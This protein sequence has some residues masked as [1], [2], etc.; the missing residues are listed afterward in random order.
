MRHAFR[1][2]LSNPAFTAAAA[3][4]LAAAIGANA[5]IFSVINGVLL[6]PLPFAEPER[7]VG[8]WHVAPGIAP[9]PMN[10][11]PSTYFTYREDGRVFQDIGLWDDTSVTV[12][13]RGEP[14]Q[15]EA[16]VVT[17]GTLPVLGVRPALGRTFTKEDDAPGPADTVMLS[18]EYWLRL[19]NGNA[20]AIGQSLMVNGRPREI[21]GVLPEDFRFL[22]YNP[23]IVLPFRFN[24]AEIFLGNFSYQGLARLKPGVTLEQ[25]NADVARLIPTMLDRFRMP[26]GF[27]REMFAGVR[28]GPLVR[29][30]EIDV[31]GDI[32]RMLWVLFGTVGLV[33]LVAC[34]N[35]ANLFLVRAEGR[36]QELA[37]RMALGA[38]TKRVARE[39][40]AEST[41]LS[42]F[43]GVIGLGLA[44]AGIRLL[45]YLQP[46]RLPRLS[47]IS[48]DPIVVLYTLGVSMVA[49]LLFGL[50]PVLK[51][52][53]PQLANA[54]KEN[55]RGSSDGRERHR[56]RNTLVVAQIALAAV[57]LV[58]SGLML[59]TFAAMRDVSPGFV[60]PENILTMRISIPQ[61][62]IESADQV[63][64]THQD[65]VRR[66]EAIAGVESV[67][68]SSSVTMDG[69]S[70][71]DPIFVED[72]PAPE[73]QVPQLRRF[74]WIGEKY[75]QTMG[76]PIVAGRAIT[77]NDILNAAPVV[78]VSEN[79]AREVWGDPQKA[80][81]RRIRN[82]P[83][84]PWREIVGVV[85]PERQNGVTEA[86]PTIIYWPM[87]MN[88][89][90]DIGQFVQRSLVYA[91]RTPRLN[92]PGFLGEV[93]QAV[94]GVNANLPLAR[95]RTMREIY[96]ESMAQTS[97]TLV[98]LGIAA[99]VT[100]LLGV[101]GIYGVIAY[102]VAQRK[103][104]VG[105]R[106]A[107]GAAAGEVQ[108]L[109]LRHATMVAG[110][111]LAIGVAGA[112]ALMRLLGSLLFGVSP[113]DPVTYAASIG[114][115]GAI[116]FLASWLP[117]RQ[118][119]RVDPSISL[120]G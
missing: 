86:A 95:V 8:V 9:G 98:I 52:A 32:G 31:I 109:F 88:D 82:S 120:R 59:R 78:M 72:F 90:W 5:L 24:R 61:A 60:R 54:L 4:T 67:G 42:L 101:V 79:Y 46:A 28:L 81:G 68:V 19:F 119:T 49:G 30:L 73:G 99:S 84:N 10:Q 18:H 106:M 70:S 47:E 114:V 100:L 17:D 2:L 51:Y 107:L 105:I 116:A 34:A 56:A 25:A 94:W 12:T 53:R 13:G 3:I 33:L 66:I 35:V 6:K 83:K 91:I 92:S 36:Q 44:Y 64:R 57:L 38:G 93:Q 113:F 102:V 65:I 75:F 118:A 23:S 37:V 115:L 69:V 1:R 112:A 22:R 55:G 50:I 45:V 16:L 40:L 96:D 76:N 26:P 71:N 48:L 20:G 39:L 110:I 89:F 11:A 111:G 63:T 21:I 15:I 85:G 87:R 62:V 41:L 43:A 29:P 104:E 7:L 77:W 97:F 117:A 27:T 103:R 80:I 14:E 58:A 108:R 74:K